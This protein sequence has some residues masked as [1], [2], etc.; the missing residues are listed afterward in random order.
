MSK[1][2]INSIKEHSQRYIHYKYNYAPRSNNTYQLYSEGSQ[3]YPAMLEAIKQAQSYV[4]IIQYIFETSLTSK[5]FIS[6][7]IKAQQRGV[8]VCL[9]GD[10][11][12]SKNLSLQE[13]QQLTNAGI[14]V[15][16][17]NP[18]RKY[19]LIKF[20]Y[21]D[22]RKLLVID[23]QTAFIGGAG[24]CDDYN[25]PIQHQQSWIDIVIKISGSLALDCESLFLNQFKPNQFNLDQIN[26]DKIKPAPLATQNYNDEKIKAS[27]LTLNQSQG[28]LL[29]SKSWRSNEIQRAIIHA[30]Q[31]SKK[32]VWITSP[33]FV[34]SRKLRSRL[35]SAAHRGCDVRLMLPGAISDHSWVNQIARHRYTRWLKNNIHIFEYQHEFSHAKAILCDDWLCIGSS[36]FDRW[37]QKFNR[38]L[39]I[40]IRSKSLSQQ[41][42]DFFEQN[43]SDCIQIDPAIWKKRPRIQRIKEWFWSKVA[44]WLERIINIMR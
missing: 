34:P 13:R 43:F 36:N 42:S 38:E 29:T 30:V 2:L 32:R 16:L 22:H 39:N 35:K 21:R 10:A 28:R 17:F 27:S 7:L 40:E 26:L 9:I 19:H 33:Y 20:L 6:A 23:G 8:K 12:G 24:I 15:S 5:K 37:N 3:F 4:Y 11:Y 25:F 1:R 31:K 41:L 44:I 18:L 14:Q